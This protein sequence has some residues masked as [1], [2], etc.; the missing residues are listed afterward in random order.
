VRECPTGKQFC[1]RLAAWPAARR[2]G[3]GDPE[4]LKEDMREALQQKNPCRRSRR[5]HWPPLG[6]RRFRRTPP[7]NEICVAHFR[8][9]CHDSLDSL[10]RQCPGKARYGGP[11]QADVLTDET[12]AA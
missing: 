6:G 11:T 9:M 1:D 12:L 7:P 3:G 2:L 8:F 10:G 5:S 4:F